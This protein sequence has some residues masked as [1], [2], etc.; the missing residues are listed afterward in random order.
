MYSVFKKLEFIKKDLNQYTK[1]DE[2]LKDAIL[3]NS[4]ALNFVSKDFLPEQ[5][6]ILLKKVTIKHGLKRGSIPADS[7]IF[8]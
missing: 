7:T 8:F 4:E 5:K 1:M 6:I 3:S 2:L